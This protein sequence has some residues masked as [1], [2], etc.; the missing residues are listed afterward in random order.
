MLA[1]AGS[2]A[3]SAG[4]TFDGC[5]GDLQGGSGCVAT[6]P[7]GAL[8]GAADVALSKN[9]T[10]L[11]MTA[12]DGLNDFTL[13]GA[14]NPT[15]T[16]CIGDLGC[17]G[18]GV[19]ALE[20]ADGLAISPSGAQLYLAAYDASD[21]S[22]FNLA[23]GGPSFA[24]CVGEFNGCAATSPAD[25][26][27]RAT[28]LTMTPD[29]RQLYVVSLGQFPLG[30]N[31][32][33]EH[34][35]SHFTLDA[36]GN[37]SFDG[38]IGEPGG[39][40]AVPIAHALEGTSAATVSP[41]GLQLYVAG[42]SDISH[43]TLDA[44]GNPSF[45]GCIGDNPGCTATAVPHALYGANRL[46]VSPNGSELYATSGSGYDVSHF[47]L[48]AA[49]DPTFVDCIGDLVGCGETRP[50]NALEGAAAEALSPDGTQLYVAADYALDRFTLGVAGDPT[51]VGCIGDL[52][53]CPGA[54]PAEALDDGQSIVFSA[55]GTQLYLAATG[56]NALD[57]L[58]VGPP[59]PA[60]RLPSNAFSFGKLELNKRRGTATLAVRVPARGS[61]QLSGPD[62]RTVFLQGPA[63]A[64]LALTLTPT[65]E[66]AT[67]LRRTHRA[68]VAFEVIYTPLFGDPRTQRKTVRLVQEGAAPARKASAPA[69]Q[70]RARRVRPGH[71]SFSFSCESEV[72]AF[73]IQAN[74]ALHSVYDPSYVFGCERS[75][76]RSFSCED[77]HTGAEEGGSGIA[78][79]SEPLCRPGAHLVL[80]VTPTFDFEDQGPPR[81]T[82]T[83]K[84]PC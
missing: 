2:A 51:F 21:L 81:P 23:T 80:R 40:T 36:A 52:P 33:R 7:V 79:V 41:D 9:E 34:D 44:E 63:A 59:P 22:V 39:C 84:G 43:F 8:D 42:T 48:N 83:L 4:L 66:A 6:N 13:D 69:C 71:V 65:G 61:I 25:A 62:V 77:M 82:L 55:N 76:S 1:H 72:S 75:T 14:G 38:C 29:G 56:A 27:A 28:S 26:L 60:P 32:P 68:T 17:S 67:L 53:G 19:G 15:F 74:R 3:A 50:L 46:L 16:G 64:R 37:P 35:V 12:E 49:G 78:T 20:L 31:G 30:E 18:S 47:S 58:T 10:Q 54:S 57:H 70:G 11:Y 73:E 5:I 24:G 45:D